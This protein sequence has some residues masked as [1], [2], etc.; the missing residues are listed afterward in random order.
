M[1][2]IQEP[3]FVINWGRAE[4][5]CRHCEE[6]LGIGGSD[7][8]NVLANASEWH[9]CDQRFKRYRDRLAAVQSVAFVAADLVQEMAQESVVSEA[10][11][12]RLADNCPADKDPHRAE[13]LE[14][15][16]VRSGYKAA[17][18]RLLDIPLPGEDATELDA[19]IEEHRTK[20]E[21]DG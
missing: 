15:F 16:Y 3:E 19:W 1:T 12:T 10:D 13:G 4:A 11:L 5:I 14:A 8:Q 21:S 7:E 2:D 6:S 9:H 18:A 20:D 17:I